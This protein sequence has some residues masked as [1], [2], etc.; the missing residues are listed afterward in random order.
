MLFYLRKLRQTQVF[1]AY[2]FL[3]YVFLEELFLEYLHIEGYF[4]FDLTIVQYVE[5]T[6]AVNSCALKKVFFDYCLMMSLFCLL[7][8][9][10]SQIVTD[11]L[12]NQYLYIFFITQRRLE[13]LKFNC[14]LIS[15]YLNSELKR[16]IF[17]HKAVENT[18][19]WSFINWNC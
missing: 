16:I 17:S 13:N 12:L 8:I 3:W 18:L 4:K 7:T 9:L 10:D 5:A 6:S 14:L 11:L 1:S 15:L 2:L 19:F